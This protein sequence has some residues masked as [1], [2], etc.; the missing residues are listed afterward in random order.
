MVPTG[1]GDHV[2]DVGCGTGAQLVRYQKTG[3]AV[4]GVDLSPSMLAAAKERL[5]QDADLQ[6]AD[7]TDL[8]FENDTFDLA[9]TSMFLHELPTDVRNGVLE[10]AS[11]VLK[12]DGHL[13]VVEF[14]AEPRRGF[15]AKARRGFSNIVE[16]VAGSEHHKNFKEFIRAG[17]VEAIVEDHALTVENV[18]TFDG[19]DLAIFVLK[20]A[21]QA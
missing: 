17:G 12:P 8:P 18:R 5:G 13:V 9:L 11:R 7:A 6:L 14:D 20:K 19:G 3:A 4:S 15:V 10:E 2:L 16:R 21:N 1:A